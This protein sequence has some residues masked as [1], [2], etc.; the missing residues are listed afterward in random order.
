MEQA[1]VR[2]VARELDFER[3]REVEWLGGSRES[4][5]DI[6]GLLGHRHGAHGIELVHAIFELDLLAIVVDQ[7]LFLDIA[8]VLQRPSGRNSILKGAHIRHAN[9]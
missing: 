2:V 7:G 4:G 9:L 8:V 5:L 6:V 1:T 3:G